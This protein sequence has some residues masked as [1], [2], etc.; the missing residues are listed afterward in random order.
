MKPKALTTCLTNSMAVKILYSRTFLKHFKKRIVRNQKLSSEFDKRIILFSEDKN[1]PVLKN[2]RLSGIKSH[3]RS[4]SIT[5]DIRVLYQQI[6][7]GEV[8]LIDI[9]S[10]NQVY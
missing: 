6:S 2:H 10:R 1:Y 7:D 3:L 9:G 8:I 5:G 4:F